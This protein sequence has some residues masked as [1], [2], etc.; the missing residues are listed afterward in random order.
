MKLIKYY[1]KNGIKKCVNE[2]IEIHGDIELI[3][4]LAEICIE[5]FENKNKILLVGN[6]SSALDAKNIGIKAITLTAD[7]SILIVMANDYSYKKMFEK[8]F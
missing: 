4:Q 8:E 7:T 1:I 5:Y 3:Q 2:K 6:V